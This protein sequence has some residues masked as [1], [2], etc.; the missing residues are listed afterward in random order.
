MLVWCI[1]WVCWLVVFVRYV[2]NAGLC[3]GLVCWMVVLVS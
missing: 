1:G 3:A 2:G